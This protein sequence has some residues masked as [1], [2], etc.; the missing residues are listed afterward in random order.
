M[1]GHKYPS[2]LLGVQSALARQDCGK[3]TVNEQQSGPFWYDC[4]ICKGVKMMI[5][6]LWKKT[7]EV[8]GNKPKCQREERLSFQEAVSMG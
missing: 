1:T 8:E 3:I 5:Y 7:G 2:T 4:R 6:K